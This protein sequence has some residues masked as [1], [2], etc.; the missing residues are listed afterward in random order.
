M[1]NS[2][3]FKQQN[4]YKDS[5]PVLTNPP[6]KNRRYK[7]IVIIFVSVVIMVIG[8][9]FAVSKIL[10]VIGLNQ[11]IQLTPPEQLLECK[12]H[13]EIDCW[14]PK[15]ACAWQNCYPSPLNQISKYYQ[16]K[17]IQEKSPN[18][19]HKVLG[20]DAGDYCVNKDNAI[21]ECLSQYAVENNDLNVCL[22]IKIKGE[23]GQGRCLLHLAKSLDRSDLCKKIE[24]TP[25]KDECL[26]SFQ[27]G[28]VNESLCLEMTTYKMRDCLRTLLKE[29]PNSVYCS[30]TKDKQIADDCYYYVAIQTQ[31][32]SLCDKI[33]DWQDST[34]Y[35][36]R[37]NCRIR[38]DARTGNKDVCP[39]IMNSSMRD[40]C[41]VE[42]SFYTKNSELCK[43]VES[44]YRK[45]ECY[46]NMT[47]QGDLY[48]P[49]F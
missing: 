3:N 26:L 5:Q 39:A 17:A 12:L 19:C 13:P 42:T 11:I 1:E 7:K 41:Y 44:D 32:K 9:Y 15:G 48:E 47:E 35:D 36:R 33:I 40:M 34:G 6:S 37:D 16:S 8:G 45:K 49:A 4:T 2:T 10:F 20:L 21:A 27:S 46:E 14:N 31:D 28:G 38:I 22:S 25:Q 29:K 43:F 18:L 23:Y 24:Y 30:K